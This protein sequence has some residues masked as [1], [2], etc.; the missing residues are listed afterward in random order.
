M[1]RNT[2]MAGL[3]P[4]PVV[5]SAC[6]DCGVGT[7]T[8]GELYMVQPEVWQQ[9]WPGSCLKPWHKILGQQVLCIGCLERRLGR[10]LTSADFTDAPLNDPKRYYMSSRLR[11][12]LSATASVQPPQ[13][14]KRRRGRPPGS[15]NRPKP[16]GSG[17][18]Q[19]WSPAWFEKQGPR[20][21]TPMTRPPEFAL[22]P[23][24]GA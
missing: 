24:G 6:A 3:Y 9:V 16:T 21:R 11:D 20:Y 12:R 7:I 23:P 17:E 19:A 1:M 18:A 13:I 2:T 10:T 14:V 22:P 8:L 15:K 5:V 4:E